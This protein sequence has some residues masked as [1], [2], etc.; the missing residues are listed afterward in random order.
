[1]ANKPKRLCKCGLE[2]YNVVCMRCRRI[3]A[4]AANATL[5]RALRLEQEKN[6][7]LARQ[8]ENL[9]GAIAAGRAI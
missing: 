8:V 7:E 5:A 3:N 1:M 4:Q 9:K 2:S 6:A